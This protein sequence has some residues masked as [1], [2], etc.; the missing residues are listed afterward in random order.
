MKRGRYMTLH[1]V[2]CCYIPP[3]ERGPAAAERERAVGLR[4]DRP[5]LPE[6][7]RAVRVHE[8]THRCA[9]REHRRGNIAVVVMR[10]TET[11][12]TASIAIQNAAACVIF[13]AAT[14][15]SG[16]FVPSLARGLDRRSSRE[17]V[18]SE[19]RNRRTTGRGAV[20]SFFS[21]R[22][23]LAHGTVRDIGVS[24]VSLVSSASSFFI[25]HAPSFFFVPLRS[26]SFLF[27]SSTLRLFVSLLTRARR[28][29]VAPRVAE[30]RAAAVLR[31]KQP[32]L[33]VEM[34]WRRIRT[35]GVLA[36]TRYLSISAGPSE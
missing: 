7:L 32:G 2:P 17:P 16:R 33:A 22:L 35:W 1:T 13:F 11:H 3:V 25:L 23:F 9:C 24:S 5:A 28:E 8:Q 4:L 34:T 6:D 10:R 19:I 18:G 26:S 31:H 29:E 12:P 21:L 27:D 20:G 30:R 14:A 15:R 36:T